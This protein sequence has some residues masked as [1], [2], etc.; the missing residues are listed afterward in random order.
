MNNAEEKTK[1][2]VIKKLAD[3]IG[4]NPEDIKDEDLLTDDL[5]MNPLEISDL[6]QSLK[7]EGIEIN[8]SKSGE[9]KTVSD[10]IEQILIQNA[11]T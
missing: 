9:I 8:E 7:E 6:L 5:H 10:L 11:V 1:K 2:I 3:S 4:V